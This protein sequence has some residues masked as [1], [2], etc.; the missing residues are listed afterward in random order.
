MLFRVSG[1][2]RR[3]MAVARL[4]DAGRDAP[5]PR[6]RRCGRLLVLP[7]LRLRALLRRSRRALA[8][9]RDCYADMVKGLIADAA[10]AEAPV[11]V[12]ARRMAEA[13]TGGTVAPAP[14]PAVVP[15]AV[16]GGVLRCNAH[17]YIR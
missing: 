15:A 17:R 12:K 1:R 4:G 3:R 5:R 11:K 14:A 6:P 10:A 8:R 2:G 7:L 9:L 13:G 16:A